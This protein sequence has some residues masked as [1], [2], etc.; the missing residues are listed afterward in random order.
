VRRHR[1]T[2]REKVPGLTRLK[3]VAP[4]LQQASRH[5]FEVIREERSRGQARRVRLSLECGP[6]FGAQPYY[7][8]AYLQEDE[9]RTQ[10]ARYTP[11]RQRAGR[12]FRRMCR[13]VIEPRMLAR[14]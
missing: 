2:V 7:R 12:L 14:S 6:Y 11:S 1:G 13:E 4:R 3:I 5:R 10:V 9:H 8:V